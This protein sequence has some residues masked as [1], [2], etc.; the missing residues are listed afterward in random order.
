[1]LVGG[2]YLLVE[3]VGE[4]GM[5]RVW[6][7]HDQ[8]LKR[9]VAVKEVL[10]PLAISAAERSNLIAR[11]M[12][13]AHAAARLNHPG[14][15][16]IHD[17]VE[18]DG[19]PWIVMEFISGR[20]LGA[21]IAAN[22]RLPWQRV[23]EIGEQVA[24]ALAYAHAAGIVHRDLKPD[25][26][27][28]TGRRAVVTDFG[29]ARILDATTQLTSP[30]TIIGTPQFMAPEQL[31]GS[32][33]AA[34]MDM[35]SLGV[36][37]YAAVQGRPPF[38]GPT[39]PAVIAAIVSQPTYPPDHAGPLT[40][41]LLALLAKDPAERPDAQ[42]VARE[43]AARRSAPATGGPGTVSMPPPTGPRPV[44][45]AGAPIPAGAGVTASTAALQPPSRPGGPPQGPGA[46]QRP[47]APAPGAPGVIRRRPLIAGV[48]AVVVA[49]AAVGAYVATRPSGSG[50]PSARGSSSTGGTF[51][52]SPAASHASSSTATLAASGPPV[53][54]KGSLHLVGSSAFLPIAK[55]AAEAYMHDCQ[56]ATIS[57]TDGDSAYG[58]TAVRDAVASGVTSAGSMI[59]MYDGSPGASDTAGLKQYPMG[60]LIYSV[61]AH[62]GL[63]HDSNVTS[64]D[65][66]K[67]F[68]PPGEPGKVAVGRLGG[69]GSRQA[70][71]KVLGQ[72]P[73]QPSGNCPAPTGHAVAFTGC[74]EGSTANVLS[75]VNQTPNAVGYAE[76]FGSLVADPQVSVLYVDNAAPTAANVRNGS[77]KF[78]TGEHLYTSAHPS[79]LTSDFLAFLPNYIASDPPSDFIACSD[80]A[81][82]AGAGC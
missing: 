37:L 52:A 19:A 31:E 4:G 50:S 49:L 59:A 36:T 28:L 2:R 16:T 8:T 34:A 35:W 64:A 38:N 80:A 12:R 70:F 18:H 67:I 60:V 74:T 47:A 26:V 41:L 42:T 24:D 6:R 30:S 55:V 62:S 53:C 48:A 15:V 29:I 33:A 54:A 58:L 11:A 75:F 40:G 79:S 39:I 63:F 46:G 21:E 45:A 7:A 73:G 57:V 77:Y 22:G 43:L 20:S 72:D 65:L 51:S 9:D 32:N 1:M 76:V 82:I 78:W 25:N 23:A 3:Q 5:G 61:V 14:V 71:K 56:G 13:E 10:L 27:L 81:N 68:V 66:G 17:A 69:S 44:T